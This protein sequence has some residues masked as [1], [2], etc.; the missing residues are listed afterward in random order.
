M[1]SKIKTSALFLILVFCIFLT[2]APIVFGA[3][4]PDNDAEIGAQLIES[5]IDFL[6]SSLADEINRSGRTDMVISDDLLSY[7]QKWTTAASSPDFPVYQDVKETGQLHNSGDPVEANLKLNETIKQILGLI[8]EHEKLS[9]ETLAAIQELLVR[10]DLDPEAYSKGGVLTS[11]A[12]DNKGTG[13]DTSELETVVPDEDGNFRYFG[14]LYDLDNPDQVTVDPE[15]AIVFGP[16]GLAGLIPEGDDPNIPPFITPYYGYGGYYDGPSFDVSFKDEKRVEMSN[17]IYRKYS[18]N[19]SHPYASDPNYTATVSAT[20]FEDTGKNPFILLSYYND[21]DVVNALEGKLYGGLA[22]LFP[23]IGDPSYPPGNEASDPSGVDAFWRAMDTNESPIVFHESD[24]N[25]PYTPVAN[26]ISGFPDRD[27]NSG[28]S[29][30]WLDTFFLAIPDRWNIAQDRGPVYS[31]TFGTRNLI[32]DEESVHLALNDIAD[33]DT[34]QSIKDGEFLDD[35]AFQEYV[36]ADLLPGDFSGADALGLL[37]DDGFLIY[38]A[39]YE[40]YLI[41]KEILDKVNLSDEL[42]ARLSVN[43][44]NILANIRNMDAL[45]E[46]LSDAKANYIQRDIHD[47]WTKTQQVV[48]RPND[49]EIILAGGSLRGADAS[50]LAGIT[51]LVLGMTFSNEGGYSTNLPVTDLPLHDFLGTES[52]NNGSFIYNEHPYVEVGTKWYK[53]INPSGEY[54]REDTSL[55][56]RVEIG[57]GVKDIKQYINSEELTLVNMDPSGSLNSPAT[58]THNFDSTDPLG[59]N[60]YRTEPGYEKFTFMFGNTSINSIDVAFWAVGDNNTNREYLGEIEDMWDA[61][62]VNEPYG[63]QIGENNLEII[64][65]PTPGT[66]DN[67]TNRDNNYFRDPIDMVYVPMSRMIWKDKNIPN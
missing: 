19:V 1:N 44:A 32:V 47:N 4:Q 10:L 62:R 23:G 38:I 67:P 28:L 42:K 36:V 50:D 66:P 15:G 17:R 49:H 56:P 58:F 21:P 8:I 16:D 64:I 12:G 7:I 11:T 65:D 13:K 45:L 25:P 34:F 51:N 46:E 48:L 60:E 27:Y 40:E 31:I 59:A 30:L 57:E 29:E 52:D 5:K 39:K 63:P 53:F 37:E 43:N 33:E 26:V 61:F 9:P 22:A 18:W 54:L 35:P 24:P 20:L 6:V 55:D 2:G 14:K 3:I 41:N